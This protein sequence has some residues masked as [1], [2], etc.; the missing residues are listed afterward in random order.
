MIRSATKVVTWSNNASSQ[1]KQINQ[2]SIKHTLYLRSVQ[3]NPLYPA[4]H[5]SEENPSSF[6]QYDWLRQLSHIL[7]HVTPY[8]PKSHSLSEVKYFL[9]EFKGLIKLC[10]AFISIV[11]RI[12]VCK[13]HQQWHIYPCLYK[14]SSSLC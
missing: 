4:E 10:V 11:L 14:Y 2:I 7:K 12:L 13:E 1:L 5:P 8:F 9:F 6:W 3:R